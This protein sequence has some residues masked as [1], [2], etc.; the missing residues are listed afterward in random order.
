MIYKDTHF[1]AD[2]TTS[3]ARSEELEIMRTG[4]P[5]TNRIH[6][7]RGYRGMCQRYISG[8]MEQYP[9]RKTVELFGIP[10]P[11]CEKFILETIGV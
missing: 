9:A 10:L 4:V 2:E 7:E 5:I 11:D 6:Q 1:F 8:H 3:V